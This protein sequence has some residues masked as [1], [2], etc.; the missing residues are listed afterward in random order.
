MRSTSHSSS[1]PLVLDSYS[2][3]TAWMNPP[4]SVMTALTFLTSSA[5][6]F[7]CVLACISSTMSSTPYLYRSRSLSHLSCSGRIVTPLESM[8]PHSNGRCFGRSFHFVVNAS[9]PRPKRTIT[10]SPSFTTSFRTVSGSRTIPVASLTA[11]GTRDGVEVGMLARCSMRR[12]ASC[13]SQRRICSPDPHST[14][15]KATSAV[16]ALNSSDGTRLTLIRI[17]STPLA[18]A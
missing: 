12:T 10:A 9:G 4:N 11:W 13:P 18:G 5:L 15:T 7:S 6:A 1:S 17:V 2:L 16:P 3:N 8:A 14:L